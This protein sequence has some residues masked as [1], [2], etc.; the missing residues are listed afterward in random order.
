MKKVIVTGANGF[1]GSSLIKKLVEKNICVEALD[2]SFEK[3]RLPK[4]E[5]IH[6]IETDL[7]DIDNVISKLRD[8][9]NY[10][11]FYH[12]AWQGVNGT[13][14][15]DPNIQISNID[16]VLRCAKM[17]KKLG[18]NKF[19]CAGTIAEQAVGSLSNLNSTSG[20]MMYGSAKHCA[21][22]MLE[23]YCKNVGLDFVWMQFS[24]IYGPENKT[25]NLVSYT[26]D[27][28][29]N[30][31]D[32]LFGPAEQIYDFIFVDDL[33]DAVVRLGEDDTK[34]NNYFIGSGKPRLLKEYLLEIG[35]TMGKE[36]RI[37]IGERQD[38]G[39]KYT[40]DMFDNSLLIEDI[41]EYV[42]KDFTEGIRYTLERY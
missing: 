3:S 13:D 7:T 8:K 19:L 41:G 10:D 29:I 14:K 2:I 36:D 1:I 39:I 28:L 6:E 5:L 9:D 16:M 21:H 22:L 23:T 33:I 42:T 35:Q 20:G 24:N 18:V 17:A 34:N 32:A 38:D 37:K 11:S 4:M 15:A 26:I 27:A 40:V 30:E 12:L 25:G 31:Q